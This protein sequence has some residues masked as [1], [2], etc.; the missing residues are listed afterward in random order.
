MTL[1]VSEASKL[2]RRELNLGPSPPGTRSNKPRT[3]PRLSVLPAPQE[4]PRPHGSAHTPARVLVA[5]FRPTNATP[6][7]SDLLLS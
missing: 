4:R 7:T 2:R 3:R 5:P 6:P 1:T